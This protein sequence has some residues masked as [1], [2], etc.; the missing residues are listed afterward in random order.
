MH[1]CIYLFTFRERK[2][3]RERERVIDVREKHCSVVSCTCPEWGQNPQRFDAQD[4]ALTNRAAPA[5]AVWFNL[6]EIAQLLSEEYQ[7]TDSQQ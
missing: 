4:G 7:C 1:V 2:G 3:G 6:T 5:R